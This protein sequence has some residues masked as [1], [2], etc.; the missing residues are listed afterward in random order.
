MKK[1]ILAIIILATSIINLT[2]IAVMVFVFMPTVKQTNRLITKVAQI[3]DLEL[4]SVEIKEPELNISDFDSFSLSDVDITINLK[5]N[6]GETKRH[7]AVVRCSLAMN[8]KEK[9]YKKV[10]ELVE[11]NK[12]R[13]TEVVIEEIGKYTSLSVLDNTENIKSNIINRL[14]KE[15]FNTKCIT[16]ITFSKFV[17]E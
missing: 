13:I 14:Q 2:L 6:E 17:T 4:E 9:D 8:K 5:L 10:K 3:V 16:G 7:F 15:V 11:Q 1:N 12:D